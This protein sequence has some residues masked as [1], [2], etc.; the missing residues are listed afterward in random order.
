MKEDTRKGCTDRTKV[1]FPSPSPSLSLLHLAQ[2]KNNKK[3][4]LIRHAT[5]AIHDYWGVGDKDCNNGIM[6]MLGIRDRYM[7]IS[8][9]MGVKMVLTDEFIN[10]FLIPVKMRRF[11]RNQQYG[12]A[13]I[14]VKKTSHPP[15]KPPIFRFMNST[16]H[17]Y[18]EYPL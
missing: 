14:T 2:Q 4:A 9:G 3:E 16:S 18:P 6:V 12:N 1:W 11:M 5:K 15:S 10:D 7:Y 17:A 8:T 13:I